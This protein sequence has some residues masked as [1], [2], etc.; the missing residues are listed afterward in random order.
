MAEK[1]HQNKSVAGTTNVVTKDGDGAAIISGP[2]D[3]EAA[4]ADT[5]GEGRYGTRHVMEEQMKAAG[6]GVYADAP[7]KKS[8][9]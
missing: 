2:A 3:N 7:K 6:A 4:A 5:G 9:G 8:N 1:K